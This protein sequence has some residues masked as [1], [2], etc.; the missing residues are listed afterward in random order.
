MTKEEILAKVAAGQIPVE[1]T[2]KLV[3]EGRTGEEGI[4]VLQGQREGSDQRLR[5]ATDA[6]YPVCRAMGPTAEFRGVDSP[7]HVRT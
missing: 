2:S 5:P 3:G 1:E 4:S 7:V 6:G